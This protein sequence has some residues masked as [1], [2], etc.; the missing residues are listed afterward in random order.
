[1][2][3]LS[4]DDKAALGFLLA[5]LIYGLAAGATFGIG[6]L[7]INLGNLRVLA[8]ESGQPVFVLCLFFFGLFVTFGSLGVGV[9]VMNMAKKDE[10][11]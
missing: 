3:P 11:D 6:V 2:M 10:A 9:G 8:L 7:F 5:H 4:P 1:M